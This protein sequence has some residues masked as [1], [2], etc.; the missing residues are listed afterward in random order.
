MS[1]KRID[2]EQALR[3]ILEYVDRELSDP[4]RAAMQ[5]HLRTCKGCFSRM[6]FERRLKERI[7]ELRDEPVPWQLHRRIKDLIKSF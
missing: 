1:T 5:A 3:L 2:C 4:Q 7:C 6:H